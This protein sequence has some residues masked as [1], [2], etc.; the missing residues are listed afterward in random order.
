M[1]TN[2]EKNEKICWACKRT[3]V[4]ESKFGLC[5]VCLNK[6]G[7]QVVALGILGIGSIV[8]LGF[9]SILKNDEKFAKIVTDV[10]K[11]S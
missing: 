11:R 8:S 5:P 4:A 10:I 1:E 3:L 9:R 2:T 7:S 6:Y